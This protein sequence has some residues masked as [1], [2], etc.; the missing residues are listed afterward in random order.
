MY[1]IYI[2]MYNIYKTENFFV[3]SYLIL[4]QVYFVIVLWLIPSSSPTMSTNFFV[5]YYAFFFIILL[6]FLEETTFR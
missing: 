6:K 2:Y 1:N 4:T 3:E 5:L